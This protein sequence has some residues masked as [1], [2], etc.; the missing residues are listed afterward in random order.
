MPAA[1]VAVEARVI[2][3]ATVTIEFGAAAVALAQGWSW[4]FH[5]QRIMACT[6]VRVCHWQDHF[7]GVSCEL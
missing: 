5:V 6:C 1:A 2:A 3:V 7:D 4:V